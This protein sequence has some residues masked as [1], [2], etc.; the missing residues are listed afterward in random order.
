MDTVQILVKLPEEV[1][2]RVKMLCAERGV[3]MNEFVMGLI[4]KKLESEGVST[5]D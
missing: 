4:K 5:N 2:R 1:R 3:S